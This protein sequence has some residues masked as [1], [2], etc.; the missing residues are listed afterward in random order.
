MFFVLKFSA[1]FVTY[2]EECNMTWITL[3]RSEDFE[4][5]KSSLNFRGVCCDY[6]KQNKTK[7]RRV[8]EC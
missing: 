5:L 7:I 8:G 1:Y 3:F 4:R 2:I 6:R